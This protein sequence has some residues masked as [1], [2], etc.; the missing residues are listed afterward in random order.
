MTTNPVA[1]VERITLPHRVEFAVLSAED[2]MALA[3]SAP[4]EQDAALI[5]TAAFTGLRL[6]ELRALRWRDVSWAKRYIYVR[7]SYTGQGEKSPKSGRARSIPLSDPV[8]CVLDALSQREQLTGADDRVFCSGA[9][10]VR[11]DGQIRDMFYAALE[12]AGIDRDRGTGKQLVFHDLRHTFGTIAVE[13]F[14]LPTVQ[15]W[16]GHSS[17]TTTMGY[18]HHV[19]KHHEADALSALIEGG[20]DFHPPFIPLDL[21]DDFRPPA[22]DERSSAAS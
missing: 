19:D 20:E 6:G 3:R 7:R 17:I 9:G 12:L 8:A 15:A 13:K 22:G 4:T 2:V 14:P 16:M 21:D 11:D 5:T 1:A 10:G 18:V